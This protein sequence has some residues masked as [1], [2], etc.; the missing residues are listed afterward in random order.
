MKIACRKYRKYFYCCIKSTEFFTCVILIYDCLFGQG[1]GI[2][3]LIPCGKNVG[4]ND[5]SKQRMDVYV[6]GN[7]ISFCTSILLQRIDSNCDQP[8]PAAAAV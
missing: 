6:G 7:A 3:C 4:E 5:E 8:P 2:L 1:L